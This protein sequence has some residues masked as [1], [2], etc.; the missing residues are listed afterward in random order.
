MTDNIKFE[1]ELVINNVSF[2]YLNSDKNIFH[3]F[4]LSI[5]KGKAIGIVENWIWKDNIDKLN[6]RSLNP[7]SGNI[8]VDGIDIYKNL[9]SWQKKWTCLDNFLMDDSILQN[10]LFLNDENKVDEEDLKM[11]LITQVYQNSLTN[12][13]QVLTL[14][15]VRVELSF[16]RSNSKSYFSKTFVQ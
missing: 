6:F 2:K 7:S 3:N 4:D 9:E 12:L 5:R 10:I 14:M 1:N 8:N 13:M 11:Q 16:W 15:L